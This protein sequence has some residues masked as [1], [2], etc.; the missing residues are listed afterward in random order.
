MKRKCIK[1]SYKRGHFAEWLKQ[2]KKDRAK[3]Y[4]GR[5]MV[6]QNME[7]SKWHNP[8]SVKKYGIKKSLQ[9][10]KEHVLHNKELLDSLPELNGK[11]LYCWCD[12]GSPCHADILI[13][14]VKGGLRK[15][16]N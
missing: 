9:L 5:R 1:S 11:T 13:E 8:F 14:L 12:E 10:Y 16:N 3:I 6:Y 7:Q 15:I 4:I 2:M